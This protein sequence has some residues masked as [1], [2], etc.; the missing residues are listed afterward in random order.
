MTIDDGPST[1]L[2]PIQNPLPRAGLLESATIFR[3]VQVPMVSMGPIRRRPPVMALTERLGLVD[4]A[5]RRMQTVAEKYGPGPLELTVPGQKMALI[6]SPQD[7]H[8][9]LE[10]TPEPFA[11]AETLKQ[12]ALAHFE[13]RV[14]LIS[15]GPERTER[16][17]FNE[18][19]LDTEHPV[20]TM[21]AQFLPAV[22]EESADLLE[23]V[24]RNG[25][26]L[27]WDLFADTWFRIVRRV[28]LGDSARDDEELM[29]LV[30]SLRSK[31]NLAFAR[32]KDCKTRA[33]FLSRLKALLDRAEPGSLAAYMAGD[34]G[35]PGVEPADQVPQW[36]FAFDP[37][38]TAAF[39]GLAL[40][41][42]DPE[43]AETARQQALEPAPGQSP[44]QL[45]HLRH[46]VLDTLRLW[47][48]T[49]LILR[50]TT[51]PVEFQTGIMP[52]GTSVLIF[53][54]FFHRDG[55][56]LSYA[57]RFSPELWERERTDGDW[58]L[59][60]F[61]DGPGVCPGKN[62]VLLLASTVMAHILRHRDVALTSHDL[63]PEA[64]PGLLN[65]YSVEYRLTPR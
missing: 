42:A 34:G 4:R 65:T 41:S 43:F 24:D 15:H 22:E 16:R 48:T 45:P 27:T 36:L 9:V 55:R 54:P 1:T 31:G 56:N 3:D 37:A 35:R 61:S 2:T 47:P 63:D 39:G 30:E 21:A 58:P 53:A 25:G 7:A 57:H 38:G 26:V 49:P 64:V 11:A 28:V 17:K 59:V 44:P 33:E 5:V 18:A 12:Q 14:S 8:R 52:A 60:P 23:A 50:E 51:R 13:P 32:P 10:G 40:L 19:A 62:L 6:L 29:E 20:H 46:T